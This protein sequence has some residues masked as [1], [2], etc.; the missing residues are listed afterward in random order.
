MPRQTREYT[1][2]VEPLD[3][4]TNEVIAREA[5]SHGLMEE[6]ELRPEGSKNPLNMWR[7]QHLFIER[8]ERSKKQLGIRFKIYNREGSGQ[9]RQVIFSKK[10]KASSKALRDAA[11]TAQRVRAQAS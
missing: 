1:W 6:R 2:Y 9:L 4:Q 10:K 8:L 11:K 3:T 5:Q 7:C